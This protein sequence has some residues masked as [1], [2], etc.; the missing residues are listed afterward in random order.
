MSIIAVI[1]VVISSALALVLPWLGV[2]A[3]YL[4]SIMQMQYLW[5]QDFGLGRVQLMLSGA[6]FLGLALA[7]ALKQVDWNRILTP[8]SLLMVLLVILVNLSLHFT[9][10]KFYVDPMTDLEM[11]GLL[12]Q[13]RVLDSFNKALI[14]YFMASL[15]IDSRKKLLCCIYVLGVVT[16]FY[17]LWANKIYVTGEFWRFGEN[18]RLGGPLGSLYLDENALA[19]MFILATPILYYLGVGQ[20]LWFIRYSMWFFIPLTWHAVFLTGSRGAL[21][22][23]GVCC[24]YIFFRSFNRTASICMA[25]GLVLAVVFQGGQ[26]LTRVDDTVATADGTE[27]VTDEYLERYGAKAIDPRVISWTVATE[28]MREFPLFGVGV[29]NFINAF[30]RYS[31]TNPHVAHN[32]YFQL[33]ANCGIGAGLIYLWMFARRLPTLKGSADIDGT[34]NFARGFKRDYLDDLLN[35]LALAFFVVALF[36]DLMTYDILYFILLMSFCKYNLDRAP[37]PKKHKLIDSI[38]RHV[39]SNRE[40]KVENQAPS[41]AQERYRTSG[42]SHL[43][44]R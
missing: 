4:F 1:F 27:Y 21:V 3:Y 32:T 2:L 6:T 15:L 35:S 7:T 39:K 8:V 9:G 5:P 37:P 44:S 31:N 17:S 24:V 25:V 34:R 38:Y 33:S 10:F 26:L 13:D 40:Q 19:M 12:T 18:G 28:I 20:K 22:S 42:N 43:S 30:P 41:L 29:G 36:L 11:P 23:L 14:F 16:L